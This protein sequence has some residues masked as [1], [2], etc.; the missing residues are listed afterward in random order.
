MPV[1]VTGYQIRAARALIGANQVTIAAA[2][3]VTRQTIERLER[4]GAQPV[5]SRDAT[6]A[7]VLAALG[8][9]GVMVVPQGGWC[10]RRETREPTRRRFSRLAAV[11]SIT[12]MFPK[13]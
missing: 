2:A 8:A 12:G 7:A 4:S 10:W 3:G 5:V 11:S 6:V 13:I 9:R 1:G